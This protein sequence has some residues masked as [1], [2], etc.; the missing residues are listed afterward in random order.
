VSRQT[1]ASV[2]TCIVLV[3]SSAGSEWINFGRGGAR[4]VQLQRLH[5]L[6]RS[7]TARGDGV[8]ERCDGLPRACARWASAAA[9]QRHWL[10]PYEA[11]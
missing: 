5:S 3:V 1:R 6:S 11:Q 2:N 9:L 7:L 8:D 4:R 10:S